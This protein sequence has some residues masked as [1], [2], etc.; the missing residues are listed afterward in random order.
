LKNFVRIAKA[1]YRREIEMLQR[2]YFV[3]S[4]EKKTRICSKR[5]QQQEEQEERHTS[6]KRLLS[7]NYFLFKCYSYF[8]YHHY[9][10]SEIEF[11]K[12]YCIEYLLVRKDCRHGTVLTSQK[13]ILPKYMSIRDIHNRRRDHRRRERDIDR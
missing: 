10:S 13:R 9:S 11:S 6:H 2:L 3:F 5:C 4:V 12:K 7:I 1:G 8:L